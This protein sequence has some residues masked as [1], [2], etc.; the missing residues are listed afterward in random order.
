MT[1][2]QFISN[3]R[4]I[5][6][7]RDLP[8]DLL[9]SLYVSIV[10]DE[11]KIE[12]REYISAVTEGWLYKQGGR[13][14]TFKKRYVILSGSVIYYYKTAKEREPLGFIPLEDVEVRPLH[15][16]AA[17]RRSA[18]QRDAALSSSRLHTDARLY[19]F[20]LHSA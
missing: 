9:A 15:N 20:K 18:T 19:R 2:E 12:Q 10:R 16:A 17:A 1:L 6:D 7:G 11:I 8:R 5:D 14:K 4:G 3:N 13:V